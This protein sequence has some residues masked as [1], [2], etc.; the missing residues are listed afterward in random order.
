MDFMVQRK[1]LASTG[2]S[3]HPPRSPSQEPSCYTDY[4]IS[5]PHLYALSITY[6]RGDAWYKFYIY[7]IY[8]FAE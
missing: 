8:R 3:T 7:E 4:D 6:F 2:N 5:R 1:S